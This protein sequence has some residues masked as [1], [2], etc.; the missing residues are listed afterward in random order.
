MSR[1]RD[2]PHPDELLCYSNIVIHVGVNDLRDDRVNV[3]SMIA[4]LRNICNC[5]CERNKNLNIVLSGALPS[6]N[7]YLNQQIHEYNYLLYHLSQSIRNVSYV[8]N[9]FLAGRD[10]RLLPQYGI[11]N[12]NDDVHINGLGTALL[13]MAMRDGVILASKRNKSLYSHVVAR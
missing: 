6:K 4:R 5:L 2:I 7:V 9:N 8:N 13:A 10:S 1:L 3:M 12:I 11:K